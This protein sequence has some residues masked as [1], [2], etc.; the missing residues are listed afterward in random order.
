LRL[1]ASEVDWSKLSP[2][3][4]WALHEVMPLISDGH[5]V[6]A[7]AKRLQVDRE[8]VVDAHELLEAEAQALRGGVVIR[9]HTEEE[10][11][12]LKASIE[13]HGQRNP[14]YRASDGVIVEGKAR[15]RICGQLR[16][17][18]WIIELDAP[19]DELESL[20]LALDVARR[21]LTASERRGIARVELLLDSTRSDRAIAVI[22]NVAPNTVKAV[23][24]DL[25]A[26]AQIAHQADRAGADGKTYPV[27]DR[28]PEPNPVVTVRIRMRRDDVQRYFSGEWNEEPWRAVEVRP[29]I[30][31]LQFTLEAPEPAGVVELQAVVDAAFAVDALLEHEPG[32][33]IAQLLR[34]AT[35]I[36]GRP[37]EQP[38]D[39]NTHEAAWCSD[40]LRELQE[41]A[42][43]A[44]AR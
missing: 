31:E 4:T 37:I 12:A 19:S 39:L 23:R 3:A 2:E 22:A 17:D 5:D 11:A 28:E 43:K 27:R 1:S 21:Q 36:F 35:E 25:E 32:A 14:I 40:R 30:F 41:L 38:G 7:I 33:T 24:R 8:R 13:L 15:M 26:G 29:G 34:D 44:A 20:S 42:E 18:P 6:D 9:K 10:F 16:I